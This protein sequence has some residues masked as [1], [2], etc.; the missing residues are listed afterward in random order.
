MDIDAVPDTIDFEVPDSSVFVRQAIIRWEQPI[1]NKMRWGI[2]VE[3]PDPQILNPAG[4]DGESRATM[5]DIVSRIKYAQ[6]S[7]RFF[8]LAGIV[9]QIRF[10]GGAGAA[11]ASATGWGVNFSGRWRVIGSDALT[12]Q[13]VFGRGIGRYIESFE[14]LGYDA[15]LT[16]EGDLQMI[17]AKS[18]VLGYRHYWRS[19]LRTTVS[20]ALARLDNEPA[21]PTDAIHQVRSPHLNLIWSP[22]HLVEIGGEIMWGERLDK[23]DGKGT[24]TRFQLGMKFMFN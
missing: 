3:D 9:R 17:P 2:A 23:D 6:E 14:G 22:W 24:A 20:F 1:A 21:Q 19:D 7:S 11:D 16:S 15:A 18:F 5:P 10:A 4:L 12:W 13:V 8:T